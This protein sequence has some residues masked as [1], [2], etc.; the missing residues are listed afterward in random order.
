MKKVYKELT[1]DQC[2][3]GVMFSSS[4]STSQEEEGTVHEI[5][6]SEALDNAWEAKKKKDRLLDDS[7]FDGSPFKFNII[8]F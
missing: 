2:M 4:L 7:F 3:R 1:D 8:R 6:H 5:T